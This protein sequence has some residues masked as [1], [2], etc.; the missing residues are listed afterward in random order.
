MSSQQDAQSESRKRKK[1]T[2]GIESTE[3]SHSECSWGKSSR[4]HKHDQLSQKMQLYS[5][6]DRGMRLLKVDSESFNSTIEYNMDY[7][8]AECQGDKDEM[9][10]VAK[11]S[12]ENASSEQYD[13]KQPYPLDIEDWD[14]PLSS[15]EML[16]PDTET[17]DIDIA[18]DDCANESMVQAR[19]S[20]SQEDNL[21]ILFPSSRAKITAEIPTSSGICSSNVAQSSV[22][23]ET[24]HSSGV[25]TKKDFEMSEG[26]CASTAQNMPLSSGDKYLIFTTGL[27][28]YTP[29][30]IGIKKISSLEAAHRVGSTASSEH[31]SLL[32]NVTDNDHGIFNGANN[33]FD[34]VDHLIELHGH[35][36]GMCLSPDHRYIHSQ[37]SYNVAFT[38]YSIHHNI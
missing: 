1:S 29:H 9:G 21:T 8:L 13:V 2:G 10:E 34:T 32:P 16:E 17:S 7:R 19:P 31:L 12:L 6:G 30:Q 15:D 33:E 26:A 27:R 36:I 38:V 4:R 18:G 24:A 23:E 5:D 14:Q 35:I 25:S 11:A 3:T 37:I 22:D 28:T 20:T